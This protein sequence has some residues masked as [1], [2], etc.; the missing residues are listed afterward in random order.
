MDVVVFVGEVVE[1][2]FDVLVIWFVVLF[3]DEK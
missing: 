1:E 3:E 2:L